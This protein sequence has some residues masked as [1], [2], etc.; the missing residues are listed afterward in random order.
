MKQQHLELLQFINAPIKMSNNIMVNIVT[1]DKYLALG[2]NGRHATFTSEQ[3]DKL[4][5][6]DGRFFTPSSLILSKQR[7]MFQKLKLAGMFF[8]N[9][10]FAGCD[11]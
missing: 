11:E 5:E 6:F 3:F 7:N 4:Q 10:L 8:H 2:K 1:E 9:C